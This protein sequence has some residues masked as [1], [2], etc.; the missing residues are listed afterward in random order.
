MSSVG[1]AGFHHS[2]PGS[3]EITVG[4]AKVWTMRDSKEK[5]HKDAWEEKGTAE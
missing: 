5:R 2:K 1:L 3:P 4:R